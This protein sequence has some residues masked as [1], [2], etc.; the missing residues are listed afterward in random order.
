VLNEHIDVAKY[1]LKVS[2]H[3]NHKPLHIIHH[4]HTTNFVSFTVSER[5]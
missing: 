4:T 1:L 5:R 2:A 3:H